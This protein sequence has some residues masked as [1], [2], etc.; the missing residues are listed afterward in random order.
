MCFQLLLRR[1]SRDLCEIQFCYAGRKDLAIVL[2]SIEDM[3]HKALSKSRS[4]IPVYVPQDVR[5]L[6]LPKGTVRPN[7]HEK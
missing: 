7:Q 6:A 4:R 3:I 1:G 2:K 5:D